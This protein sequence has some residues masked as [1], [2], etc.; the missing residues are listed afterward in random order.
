M[1]SGIF[2]EARA[3][4]PAE[5]RHAGSRLQ[6]A[7]RNAADTVQLAGVFCGIH[8]APALLPPS[9]WLPLVFDFPDGAEEPVL[10]D[11]DEASRLMNAVF[12]GYNAYGDAMNRGRLPLPF[13][14]T[15]AATGEIDIAKR[16]AAGFFRTW[17]LVP[18]VSA[19]L[20]RT[21]GSRAFTTLGYLY[22][23]MARNAVENTGAPQDMI[24]S[25]IRTSMDSVP[26][27][28]SILYALGKELVASA[29]PPGAY[30]GSTP[31][32]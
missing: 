25:L 28:V 5:V 24:A 23:E 7:S 21:E 11:S 32:V 2:L 18:D 3:V 4:L 6:K 26:E 31:P 13:K 15:S 22:G 29:P 8:T 9:Q 27:N 20:A 17:A 1:S 30:P 12:S 14:Y 16:W 19:V 10:S